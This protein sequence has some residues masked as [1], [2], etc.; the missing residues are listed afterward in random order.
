M[1]SL[2][3]AYSEVCQLVQDFKANERHFLSPD[4]QE[5]E[6]RKDY[7]DKFFMALGWDVNHEVQKNPY[8]QEVKVEK[9]VTVAR[10]Q[11]RAD[12]AFYIAHNYR[13]PKFFVEAKKPSRGLANQDDYFQ[14]LRYGWNANTPVAVLTDFEEFHILD[15][16]YK[17]DIGTALGRKLQHLHY[18]EYADKDKFAQIYYLFA[19]EAVADNA[20]GKFAEALPK[21]R[22]KAVQR[23]LF[24]G[25]Y[26]AIDEAFLDEI[27]EIRK[28]LAKSFKKNNTDLYDVELTEATQR[29]IDRLV[30][31]RFLEDKLIEPEHFIS[32]LGGSNKAWV[33]FIALS[34]RLDKKYNGVVFKESAID[35]A[36]YAE[37]EDAVFR[38]ICEGLSHLNSPY[39]FNIIPIH[40]IGSIYERFLGK[41]VHATPKRADIIDKPE[42][43]KAGGVYYT[44]Q[45]IVRYIVENTIGK[46]IE[47]KTPSEIAKLRF[48]DIS[49]GSGS[50]LIG[51]FE[52]LIDYHNK[53]YQDNPDKAKKDGCLNKDGQWV[54]SIKQKQGILLN[55]IYGV[56]IDSQAVEV[57]QLSL[58]LK[59]LEDETTAT[60]NE[61]DVLFHQAVLPDLTKNIICGNSLIGTDILQGDLF[62]LD[63]DEERKLKPM[64][65][66]SV[67]PE[68]MN[69]GG[70]DAVIGNPP[71]GSKDVL[72]GT[73]LPYLNA[74][75]HRSLHNINIFAL[76]IDMTIIILKKGAI[77]G[78]L[79]PKNFVKTETY[80]PYRN[81]ILEIHGIDHIV[82][83][84]KFPGVAQ[85]AVGLFI[86]KNIIND[87]IYRKIRQ[88]DDSEIMLSS[89][90][91]VDVL[92]DAAKVI[93]LSREYGIETILV[94]M[95]ASAF[96]LGDEFT[97]IRGMEHGRNGDLLKCPECSYFFERPGKRNK[98]LIKIVCKHCHKTIRVNDAKNYTFITRS[99]KGATYRPL[100]MGNSIDRYTLKE[101]SFFV[102]TGLKGIDYKSLDE[103]GEKLLFI[104]IS[105]DLRGYLD[106]DRLFCLNAL[107]I[108]YGKGE[109]DLKYIL[110]ILNS[111]LFK[112]YVDYKITSGATLT[113]RLSNETMRNLPIHKID[114][115]DDHDK[116]IYN[117]IVNKVEQMI[118]SKK[119]IAYLKTD[120][121]R[122]YYQQKCQGLDKK[123]DQLVYELYGLTEEEIKVVE[124]V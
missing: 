109:Y 63:R 32:E 116:Y 62:K 20:L 68:V 89:L 117:D 86:V 102:E 38:D 34:K 122:S 65:F 17:P 78:Y 5:A 6:V 67:F 101:V 110:G 98:E 97:V 115:T 64:D 19:R 58:A 27:D 80:K 18:S 60:A 10:A 36:G 41:E 48:A 42:V 24:P 30:F 57:T 28:I 26:Q 75:Y 13:D 76:F 25:G 14:T 45:Y 7:I 92:C 73:L 95:I 50:F 31:I 33:D 111:T 43:R 94:K 105:K 71:W 47:G 44:P 104:R 108:V 91:L 88:P 121:D 55:N 74:K 53:W 39:D 8:E 69:N 112:K 124:G 93:T 16:R 82:D 4:Y 56:D 37:P 90:K 40:I 79:I 21:H 123:I 2:E 77:L 15:C 23:G 66:A 118:D 46:L 51:A 54:L 81:D 61:M 29:T 96:S 35:Q 87:I 70:F 114:F 52:C 11:K 59:M 106:A 99:N 84:G 72:D 1:T 100:L 49:C 103:I 22:G 120:A 107:N 9:G 85:E 119:Q 113:I 83:F 12:Y 3:K